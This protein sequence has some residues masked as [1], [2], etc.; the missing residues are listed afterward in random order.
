MT[1]LLGSVIPAIIGVLKIPGAMVITRMPKRA[2]SRAAGR[3]I[4]ATPPLDAE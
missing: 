2:S 1:E 4:A 3:V